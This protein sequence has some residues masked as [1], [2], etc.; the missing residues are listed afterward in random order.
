MI[1]QK[2]YIQ[3]SQVFSKG[4]KSMLKRKGDMHFFNVMVIVAIVSLVI[5]LFL[6]W[7]K[8]SSAKNTLFDLLGIGEKE[9]GKE[10][11]YEYNLE[12][13]LAKSKPEIRY[14]EEGS[15]LEYY[16]DCKV[17]MTY[18]FKDG[19]FSEGEKAVMWPE[20]WEEWKKDP[21]LKLSETPPS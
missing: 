15:K 18:Y 9:E 17:L 12:E 8:L 6:I 1:L 16:A 7:P 4:G 5:I 20:T 19:K 13:C 21:N 10:P 2:A 14:N 3:V 11:S